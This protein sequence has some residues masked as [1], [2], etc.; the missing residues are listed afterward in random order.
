MYG[1]QVEM[2]TATFVERYS[3]PAAFAAVASVAFDDA[4]GLAKPVI[5]DLKKTFQQQS[6]LCG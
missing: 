5:S 3:H 6:A 1:F 4:L 2:T